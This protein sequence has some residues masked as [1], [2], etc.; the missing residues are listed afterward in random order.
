VIDAARGL[1]NGRMLPAGPLRESGARLDRVDAVVRLFAG[2]P[3]PAAREGGRETE[4]SYETLPWRNVGRPN[5]RANPEAWRAGVVHAVAG[6]GDPTRFFELLRRLGFDPVCHAFPDHHR[7]TRADLA[8][9]DA[10]AVLM[11]EKDAVKCTAFADS[12]WWYLPIMAHIDAGLVARVERTIRG[13]Q[14]A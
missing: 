12:R 13:R 1:G 9:H 7:Y 4:M 11:T 2:E 14:A 8:F 6:I 3:P 5:T 10:A